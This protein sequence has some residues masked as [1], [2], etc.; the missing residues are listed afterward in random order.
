[1]CMV[2]LMCGVLKW[3]Y[4]SPKM[5]PPLFLDLSQNVKLIWC[6]VLANGRFR[7]TANGGKPEMNS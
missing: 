7:K 6:Q 4:K 1:M 5:C 2:K 3:K